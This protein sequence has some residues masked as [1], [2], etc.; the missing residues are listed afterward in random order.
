M[1]TLFISDL[2]LDASRPEITALFLQFLRGQARDA[3][4]LY[5]LGDLFE[6][7]LGD[8]DP[9]P[10]HAG[11]MQ[12]IRGLVDSGI[13]VH[14][15]HGNRDFLIGAGFASHTGV[16]LLPDPTLV[17]LHGTPT[18]LMHGDTLCTDDVEYQQFRKY[19]R[20]PERQQA[21]L[22]S[23]LE[24]RRAFVAQARAA[25]GLSTAQKPDEIMDVNQQTVEAVMRQH[26]V[27]CLIHGHTHR[28]GIHRFRSEGRQKT[29]YVLGDWYHQGSMLHTENHALQLVSLPLA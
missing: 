1:L 17:Q 27:D 7:W 29:R 21:F 23:P 24:Q 11:V 26:G 10:H 14:F 16:H 25:S 19:A 13:P 28:P 3:E 4:A 22:A 12:A 6:A 18:L 20:D 5:I 15:M 8:D 9:D 2:H